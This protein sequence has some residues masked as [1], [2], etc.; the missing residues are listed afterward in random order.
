MKIQI[1]SPSLRDV[2]NKVN[3]YFRTRNFTKNQYDEYEKSQLIAK[4]L[5]LETALQKQAK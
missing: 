4:I 1:V 2:E 3:E 5:E